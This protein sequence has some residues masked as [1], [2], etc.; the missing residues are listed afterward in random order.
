MEATALTVQ[1][2]SKNEIETATTAIE[3]VRRRENS[4]YLTSQYDCSICY[5]TYFNGKIVALKCGHIFHHKCLA[6]WFE[7]GT[8]CPK[9]SQISSMKNAL[10]VFLDN[11]TNGGTNY[12]NR[13]SKDA[14]EPTDTISRIKL[15]LET[16]VKNMNHR[17]VL[18][19]FF[20]TL[21]LIT[22]SLVYVVSVIYNDDCLRKTCNLMN[23]NI[24]LSRYNKE[25]KPHLG[26]NLNDV[27]HY[28]HNNKL[29]DR[30]INEKGYKKSMKD[31]FAVVFGGY[32]GILLGPIYVLLFILFKNLT[33]QPYFRQMQ[34]YKEYSKLKQIK[35]LISELEKVIGNIYFI[36][37]ACFLQGM[38][39]LIVIIINAIF[40]E[41]Y[42]NNLKA[43]YSLL[44]ENN[45]KQ[46]QLV[47]EQNHDTNKI[48]SMDEIRR[49]YWSEYM[50]NEDDKIFLNSYMTIF[51]A[52]GAFYL[53]ALGSSVVM[54]SLFKYAVLIKKI[55]QVT[56]SPAVSNEIRNSR[57]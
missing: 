4:I 19:V 9:C 51:T 12:P 49:V 23:E 42:K 46:F 48:K 45:F 34:N 28:I 40:C 21:F 56:H 10:T 57:A 17:R 11:K 25:V 20:S 35:S 16:S 41:E 47:V 30:Y 13:S 43:D 52:A 24:V 6:H 7:L 55:N 39:Y 3:L 38:I 50:T 54:F 27:K 18:T 15:M 31:R 14:P 1:M 26:Q 53:F 29:R 8:T 5:D 2:S 33:N 37:K 36:S 22:I 44:L 32:F